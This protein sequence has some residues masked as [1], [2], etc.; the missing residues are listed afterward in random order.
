MFYTRIFDDHAPPEKWVLKE[1][2]PPG[3]NPFMPPIKHVVLNTT[4]K[5]QK[6]WEKVLDKGRKQ[7]WVKTEEDEDGLLLIEIKT[8]KGP[9]RY[10]ATNKLGRYCVIDG[11]KL[12]DDDHLVE[13]GQ[14]ARKYVAEKHPTWGPKHE[15]WDP[16]TP[17]GYVNMTVYV[18][19][20]VED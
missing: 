13:S 15:K 8:D 10:K 20:L 3:E 4:P 18:C 12:E 17:S 7:G 5:I 1:N 9:V 14:A 2:P 11:E 19:E 16:V 6:F